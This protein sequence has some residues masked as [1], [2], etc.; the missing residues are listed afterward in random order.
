MPKTKKDA[1]DQLLENNVSLQNKTTDILLELK[2]LVKR[3]DKML[4]LFEGAADFI[5]KEK[6][7]TPSPEGS[8]DIAGKL[9]Q[10]IDTNKE[11]ARALSTIGRQMPP[12]RRL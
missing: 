6:P 10:V 7:S 11:L 1:L 3:M 4:D 2:H 9:D 12:P 5:K 8:S